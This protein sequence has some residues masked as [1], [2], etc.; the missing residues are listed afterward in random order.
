MD[1]AQLILGGYT[2]DGFALE[3]TKDGDGVLWLSVLTV[4]AEPVEVAR[5]RVKAKHLG[6]AA[7]ALEAAERGAIKGQ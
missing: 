7:E 1:D 6:E 4:G 5:S 2:F 3:V